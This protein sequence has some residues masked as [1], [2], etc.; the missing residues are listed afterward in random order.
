MIQ[1]KNQ[2]ITVFESVLYKTTSVVVETKNCILVV[3]PNLLPKEVEEIRQYVNE[4]KGTKSIYL[5]FTHSD[6]DH[7]VGYGAFQDATVIASVMLASKGD[8][9][10]ILNQINEFDDKFYLDR[11]YPII[12]PHVDIKVLKDGQELNIDN[13][14]LTFYKAEGHTNDSIFIVIEPIGLWITGDYFSDVEF[15]FIYFNTEKYIETLQKTNDIIIKH[16]IQYLVPGH[17]HLT[18]QI[19][20]IMKRKKESLRYIEQ[21]RTAVKN[22]NETLYLLEG[23]H[24]LR[25]LI[26]CHEDNIRLIKKEL[27]DK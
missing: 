16:Q 19:E 23:Y 10:E 22:N 18:D 11:Q 13:T 27:G 25:E 3:D 14:K 21:L 8:K 12:Y 2:N 6:W 7:I 26:T 20:E 15:P 4:I 1:Y 5:I 9:D 17:G 24:Y